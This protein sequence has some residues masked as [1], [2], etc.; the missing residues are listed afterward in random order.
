VRAETNISMKRHE[1]TH[2]MAK[3]A[4]GKGCYLK[5]FKEGLEKEIVKAENK[6]IKGPLRV[7]HE[8]GGMFGMHLYIT[9]R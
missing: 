5:H 9:G 6:G 4:R 3:T 7:Y 2:L 1:I 8:D